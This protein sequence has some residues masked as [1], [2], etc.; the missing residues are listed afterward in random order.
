M[1]QK[2]DEMKIIKKRRVHTSTCAVVAGG[3][4]DLSAPERAPR[5]VHSVCANF[6][7]KKKFFLCREIA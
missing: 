4:A 2:D 5:V 7:K 1:S 6:K 3:H